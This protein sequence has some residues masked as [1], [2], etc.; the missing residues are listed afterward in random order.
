MAQASVAEITDAMARRHTQ[1]TTCPLGE[2]SDFLF[3]D[4]HIH[5]LTF[6]ALGQ[7]EHG[8]LY[9]EI[10]EGNYETVFAWPTEAD[11]KHVW[12]VTKTHGEGSDPDVSYHW[13]G[14]TADTEGAQPATV[15]QMH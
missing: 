5:P 1:Q 14:V 8:E 12:Y 11:V 15:V 7:A 10:A 9:Q 3:A 4:G 2:E 6:L 13:G